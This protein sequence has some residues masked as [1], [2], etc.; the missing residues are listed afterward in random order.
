MFEPPPVSLHYAV[1]TQLVVV[2]QSGSTPRRE[3]SRNEPLPTGR[4][5]VL[6]GSLARREGLVSPLFTEQQGIRVVWITL[7][8]CS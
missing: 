1:P 4:V 8:A 5:V 2:V 6:P 3:G 7:V